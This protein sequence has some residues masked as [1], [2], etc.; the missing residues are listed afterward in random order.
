MFRLLLIGIAHLAAAFSIV[1]SVL[2]MVAA[3]RLWRRRR[4]PLATNAYPP[5]TILKPIKGLDRDLYGNLASFLSQDYPVF[6]VLFCLQ[7]PKDPA[8][9]VLRRLR[10]DFP[11][12]DMEIL[13]S[14]RRI[15]FNPKVNNIANAASRIRH[16]LILISDSDIRAEP[17]CLKKTVAPLVADPGTGL[18]TCF[19]ASHRAR[20]LGAILES[21]S[22]NA[23]FLPQAAVASSLGGMQFVMGAV[24]LVRRNVFERAGGFLKLSEH[25]ADDFFLGEAVRALGYRIAFSDSIVSTVPDS[26][27]FNAHLT[28]IFRW[29]RTIRICQ[30]A[31]YYASVFL[32]G[33]ALLLLCALLWDL[34]RASL[35]LLAAVTAARAIS[36]GWIHLYCLG[37]CEIW[38]HLPIL[39]LS[40]LTQF[41]AW[42]VGMKGRS[43][44]WR[45]ETFHILSNGQLRPE[46][47]PEPLGEV[48]PAPG[49]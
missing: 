7:D 31:G 25:L 47:A 29:A 43:V 20:R 21:L 35:L 40:D 8:L 38:G 9:S 10:C 33:F 34:P 5:I 19:Y 12:V 32:H 16:G 18:V 3:H 6:Q 39:W 1:F 11:G 46:R 24:M 42:L 13:V 48:V 30:P 14:E 36:V 2:S 45:G 44:V 41:L 15:G 26:W 49:S 23:H 28:H 22:I 4:A 37:N 27:N 17:D